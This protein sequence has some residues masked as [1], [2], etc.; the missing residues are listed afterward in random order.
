ILNNDSILH[1][2]PHKNRTLDSVICGLTKVKNKDEAIS[3]YVGQLLSFLSTTDED[4]DMVL[5]T[6]FI[7]EHQTMSEDGYGVS[8]LKHNEIHLLKNVLYTDNEE[9]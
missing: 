4:E 8:R 3:K 5:P 1:T 7:S 9:I 2:R 6:F